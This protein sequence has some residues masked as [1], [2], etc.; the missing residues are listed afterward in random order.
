MK[1]SKPVDEEILQFQN[2]L[3]ESVRQMRAGTA[4]STTVV[5]H[6]ATVSR[7]KVDVPKVEL[8]DLQG[9]ARNAL[10]TEHRD[11]SDRT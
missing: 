11:R 1:S 6:T 7:T 2:D 5:P 4:A 3:L 10:S 8:K 9:I